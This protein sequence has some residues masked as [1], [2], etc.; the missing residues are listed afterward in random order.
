MK[1]YRK[2]ISNREVFDEKYANLGKENIQIEILW[3][4]NQNLLRL[5]K[6]ETN[7][8]TMITWLIIIPIIFLLLCG[9]VKFYINL[10]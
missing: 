2:G 4:L 10:F 8:K 5:E 7:T 9:V 6:I 1:N 3:Y